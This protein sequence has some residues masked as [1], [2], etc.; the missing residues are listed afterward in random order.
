MAGTV[1][2]RYS[3]K[4]ANP[5]IVS[6]SEGAWFPQHARTRVDGSSKFQIAPGTYEITFKISRIEVE[7]MVQNWVN[8]QPGVQAKIVR[9]FME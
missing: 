7:R 5:I 9:S 3:I 1:S 6:E 4:L 2:I 8:Y